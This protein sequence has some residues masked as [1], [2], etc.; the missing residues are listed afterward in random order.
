MLE[1]NVTRA[2]LAAALYLVSIGVYTELK[3]GVILTCDFTDN[4]N[5]EPVASMSVRFLHE[6]AHSNKTS[7]WPIFDGLFGG[8]KAWQSFE[9]HL[10]EEMKKYYNEN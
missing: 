6:V 10:S 9:D 1:F 8:R 3:N 4:S 2:A 7:D 5:G